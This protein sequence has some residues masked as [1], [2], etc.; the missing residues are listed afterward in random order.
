MA[1]FFA[2]ISALALPGHDHDVD[3]TDDASLRRRGLGL[4]AVAA[5]RAVVEH[6]A[7]EEAEPRQRRE[8]DQRE[9]DL[10]PPVAVHD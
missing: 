6:A 8:R 10:P 9:E 2:M 7:L 4:W 1:S 5:A 3:L